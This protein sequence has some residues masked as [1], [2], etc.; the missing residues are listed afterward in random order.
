VTIDQTTL[1]CVGAVLFAF[2]AS[3]AGTLLV[4]E[5]FACF[6]GVAF[7]EGLLSFCLRGVHT[8]VPCP[9]CGAFVAGVLSVAGKASSFTSVAF[10]LAWDR[11]FSSCA[12]VCLCLGRSDGTGQVEIARLASSYILALDAGCS[13]RAVAV[14]SSTLFIASAAGRILLNFFC[15]LD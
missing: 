8:G 13:F 11:M 12:G 2:D 4:A 3:A 10:L 9:R 6:A 15:Y 7:G 1:F 14:T 5:L